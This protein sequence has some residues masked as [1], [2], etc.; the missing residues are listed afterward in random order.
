M[1]VSPVSLKNLSQF[2]QETNQLTK[3]ALET[4]LLFLL[5][6]KSLAQITISELVIKAGVSRNAF[7]RNYKSKE[8]M[9]KRILTAVTRRI[10]RRLKDFNLKTQ[11]YQAWL[12]LFNEAKKEAQILS[13]A[14][15]HHLETI[16][17][18]IV[19][20]RFKAYQRYRQS[21][22]SSY[23]TSFFSNAIVSVLGKWVAD[24]MVVSAEEMAAMGLP[25]LPSS[26]Y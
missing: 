11:A 2:N 13:L 9:L 12:Y 23:A 24:G 16:I 7:Y 17:T 10:F 1:S 14:F 22:T 20:K 25:L 5:E 6:T 19:S 8:D 15:Q 3:E 18:T 4:A 26:S 21:K